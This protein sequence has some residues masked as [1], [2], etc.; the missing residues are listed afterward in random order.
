M[1]WTKENEEILWRTFFETQNVNID[2]DKLANGW[3]GA[4][5]PTPKALKEHLSKFRKNLRGENT[6]TFSMSVKRKT[7][8]DVDGSPQKKR[9]PKK[10][11]KEKVQEEV[12]GD[13]A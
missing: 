10:A 5:K 8:S 1:R 4:E 11:K 12:S 6:V 13:D 7:D 3:P 2:L 9:T